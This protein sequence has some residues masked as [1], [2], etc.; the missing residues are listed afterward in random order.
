M[1]RQTLVALLRRSRAY[2]EAGRIATVRDQALQRIASMI[3]W[4]VMFY[5]I[6]TVVGY[7]MPNPVLYVYK[8]I[9]C[10]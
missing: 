6:S 5:G 2:I 9:V 3:G 10:G 4:L 8:R 1:E 7:L